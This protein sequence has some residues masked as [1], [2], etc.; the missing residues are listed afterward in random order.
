MSNNLTWFDSSE[1]YFVN[2]KVNLLLSWQFMTAL[3]ELSLKIHLVWRICLKVLTDR[4][5]C[6]IR[7][8]VPVNSARWGF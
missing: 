1:N 2:A 3:I 7:K 6:T 8:V 5:V 4:D